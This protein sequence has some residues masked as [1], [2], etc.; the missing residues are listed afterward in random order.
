MFYWK[1][2]HPEQ[3]STEVFPVF[4]MYDTTHHPFYGTP[5]YEYPGLVK[6][7]TI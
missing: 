1:A 7:R 6:V 5:I 4:G 2:D 3:Y